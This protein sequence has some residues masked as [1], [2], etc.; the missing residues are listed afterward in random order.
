[1]RKGTNLEQLQLLWN[2]DNCEWGCNWYSQQSY[3]F[4][5][6]CDVIIRIGQDPILDYCPVY[7]DSSYRGYRYFRLICCLNNDDGWISHGQKY[8]V[9]V[10]INIYTYT[11]R[12]LRGRT[13]AQTIRKWTSMTNKEVCGHKVIESESAAVVILIIV[14]KRNNINL[15]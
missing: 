15:S 9:C 7:C 4:F 6:E 8:V 2:F 14:L 10:Y 5:T 13:L 3:S 11:H 12:V 1:M